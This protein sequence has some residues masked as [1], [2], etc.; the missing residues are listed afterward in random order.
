MS[1]PTPYILAVNLDAYTTYCFEGSAGNWKLIREMPCGVGVGGTGSDGSY[2][3]KTF[4]GA[5][6]LAT[7]N[8]DWSADDLCGPRDYEPYG[9]AV[10]Y[11][12][13][14]FGSQGFHSTVGWTND[15]SQLGKKVSH[16]CVRLLPAD[17][18]FI[19]SSLPD[20]TEIIIWGSI[21]D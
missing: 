10:R 12:T 20:N 21:Y 3:G 1:S 5:F 19:Y 9:W 6:R 8:W 7:S 4:T 2:W 11:F 16:G 13:S 17:A 14:I 15:Y 18:E